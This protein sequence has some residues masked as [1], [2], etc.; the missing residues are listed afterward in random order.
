M[1]TPKLIRT[2]VG[3]FLLPFQMRRLLTILPYYISK[4]DH[5]T[6]KMI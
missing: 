4:I 5:L 3:F 6:D 1:K 2:I